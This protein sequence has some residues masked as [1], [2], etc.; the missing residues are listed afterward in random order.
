MVVVEATRGNELLNIMD[1][2]GYRKE[3]FDGLNYYFVDDNKPDITIHN[4]ARRVLSRGIY[5]YR[6]QQLENQYTALKQENIALSQEIA[7]LKEQFCYR[8]FLLFSRFKYVVFNR[9]KRHH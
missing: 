2:F 3:F 5:T 8:I 7:T 4:Y 1:S 6:E 9:L